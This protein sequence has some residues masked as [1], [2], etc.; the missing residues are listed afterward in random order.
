[1]WIFQWQR[2]GHERTIRSALQVLLRR[3]AE[4]FYQGLSRVQTQGIENSAGGAATE[5]QGYHPPQLLH[6]TVIWW[7]PL[8]CFL[9]WAQFKYEQHCFLFWESRSMDIFTQSHI[10]YNKHLKTLFYL[11][12]YIQTIVSPGAR[13]ID[14]EQMCEPERH[15]F[16]SS[17]LYTVCTWGTGGGGWSCGGGGR[18]GC[19]WNRPPSRSISEFGN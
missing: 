6:A 12:C 5:H 7:R 10:N 1:M 3:S 16:I 15:P 13:V 14:T 8:I 4:G 19:V 17:F 18:G 2:E 9:F 11:Q